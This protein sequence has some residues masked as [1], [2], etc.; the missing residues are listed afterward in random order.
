MSSTKPRKPITNNKPLT[1]KQHAF[2]Q[3]LINNPKQ[4]ATQAALK[5]YGTTDK[6]TTYNTAM[7][8]AHDNLSKP[9]IVT[10]LSKYN[11][12]VENSIITTINRYKDSDKLTEVQEAMTNARWVHDKIHGKAT[13][14]IQSTTKVLNISIDLSANSDDITEV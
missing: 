13:Q 11:N 3:E 7:Q 10:E 2:V 14:Q 8:I 1:R 4:S 9:N 6:P 12:M 5:T